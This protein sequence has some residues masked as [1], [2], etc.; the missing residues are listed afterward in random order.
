LRAEQELIA[1][2]ATIGV[3]RAAYFPRISLTGVGG[4]RS[5]ALSSLFSGPAGLW[6]L[7]GG[8]TQPIFSGGRIRAGVR[9]AEAREQEALLVYQ[10]TI[11]QAFRE[12]SDAL[13]AY[14]KGRELRLQQE[15]LVRSAR[16]ASQLADIRYRA[17]VTSYLEV[18]TNQT[19][20]FEAELGQAQ[21]LAAELQALVQLYRAL[22]GGWEK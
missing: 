16:D 3:A 18:L 15:L 19:N 20:L 4:F 5:S 1:L 17:G 6:S 13:V 21:A 2:N 7:V 22:G 9:L 8:L 12:V 14:R 10:Q 11:Q